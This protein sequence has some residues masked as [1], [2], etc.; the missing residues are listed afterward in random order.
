[1]AALAVARQGAAYRAILVVLLYATHLQRECA[2]RSR[3]QRAVREASIPSDHLCRP[4][5][6]E[7]AFFGLAGLS[8][9]WKRC[10]AKAD[11]LYDTPKSGPDSDENEGE[12][13]HENEVPRRSS[14]VSV[15][16]LALLL[17][18]NL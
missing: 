18:V 12:N 8:A 6:Q 5:A 3:I 14:I 11:R 4:L 16:G 2:T 17:H 10:F 15:A 7:H 9:D 1:M 13:E